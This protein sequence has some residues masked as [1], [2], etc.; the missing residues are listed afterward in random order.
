MPIFVGFPPSPT[1]TEGH[2]RVTFFGHWHL[3]LLS[4]LFIFLL[5]ISTSVATETEDSLYFRVKQ[6]S[7]EQ[8]HTQQAEIVSNR[9]LERVFPEK[10]QQIGEDEVD[11]ALSGFYATFCKNEKRNLEDL[12]C[13]EVVDIAIRSILA[14]VQATR[15]VGR[16]LQMLAT[17][18]EREMAGLTGQKDTITLRLQSILNIWQSGIDQSLNPYHR[19]NI[20][21]L[22]PPEGAFE[23]IKNQLISV[24]EGMIEVKESLGA[25]A[26]GQQK[27]NREQYIAAVW[28]YRHGYKSVR[29]S[30]DASEDSCASRHE[31]L[32]GTELQYTRKVW[33]NLEEI[34]NQAVQAAQRY[35]AEL[36]PPLRDNEVAVFPPFELSKGVLLWVRSDDAGLDFDVAIE[37]VLP[38]M[39]CLESDQP[40]NCIDNAILGGQYPEPPPEPKLNTGLCS[41]PLAKR[42][43]LCRAI[44]DPQLCQEKD[45][46]NQEQKA[47]ELTTCR[48]PDF[49]DDIPAR[50]TPSGFDICTVGSW[51][52][53]PSRETGEEILEHCR[54]CTP[55]FTC[56]GSCDGA[57]GAGFTAVKNEN[58]EIEV[59]LPSNVGALPPAVT[60]YLALHEMARVQQECAAPP[61][62]LTDYLADPLQCCPVH[63]EAATLQ[64]AAMAQDGLLDLADISLDQCALV[65]SEY[66]CN[67]GDLSNPVCTR[68]EEE[69]LEK[70]MVL[71]QEAFRLTG[72]LELPGDCNLIADQLNRYVGGEEP[73][74]MD[75]RLKGMIDSLNRSCSPDC[76]SVYKNTIGNQL[77]Y[78]GQCVEE[79]I[80]M[81]RLFPGNTPLT[82]AGQA[83]G[84][85]SC[86]LPQSDPSL[87]LTVP[88]RKR[89]SF[90]PYNPALL[91]HE[92]DK[93]LCQVNG[94][95][96]LTPPVLCS[97]DLTRRMAQ[98]LQ[99]YPGMAESLRNQEQEYE[100]PVENIQEITEQISLRIAG[101][102]FSDHFSEP[103]NYLAHL[104]ESATKQLIKVA[105]I[106][107]PQAMCS[108]GAQENLC[109]TMNPPDE[110]P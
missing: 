7:Y 14:A 99:T 15:T 91:I 29:R 69:E 82:S 90:P 73:E 63:Y 89:N 13:R 46:N 68:R 17:T 88:Q 47:I 21:Y 4:F 48:T 110:E 106:S 5:P 108:R 103:W 20:R 55:H 100:Y 97:T 61:G 37:S 49:Q 30:L 23:D 80:E 31:R 109:Q 26:E 41:H 34:L 102:L 93:A 59:C 54:T 39:D 18:Y 38:A 2:G 85:D 67:S 96:P 36:N 105:D 1:A 56:K 57:P 42:G 72:E 6:L 65:L 101:K 95:P 71:V 66:Y 107:F 44:Q 25:A 19:G 53:R 78:L 83:Y 51:K 74:E 76:R 77:C 84:Y 27:E 92:L 50:I 8:M 60:I 28:R 16:D 64:C 75:G 32:D 3:I 24:L 104:V 9:F 98:P 86:L 70:L 52:A 22:D 11:K 43:Y 40:E 94:L 58:G 35:A 87:S 81:Y 45:E 33:C 79:G 12:K 10:D 62:Y